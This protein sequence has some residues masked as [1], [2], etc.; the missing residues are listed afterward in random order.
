MWFDTANNNNKMKNTVKFLGVFTFLSIFLLLP[1][2]IKADATYDFYATPSINGTILTITGNGEF[3]ALY[4]HFITFNAD[5]H[6]TECTGDYLDSTYWNLNDPV[7]GIAV[8]CGYASDQGFI[9]VNRSNSLNDPTTLW[10]ISD[11]IYADGPTRIITVTPPDLS[12]VATSTSRTIGYSGFL[13]HGDFDTNRIV[14]DLNNSA[15]ALEQCADVICSTLANNQIKYHHI[16]PLALWGSFNFSDTINGMVQGTYYMTV[17]VQKGSV[18]VFGSCLFYNNITSTSTQFTISTTTNVDL[19]VKSARD[20]VAQLQGSADSA[21]FDSCKIFN[22]PSTF[23]LFDCGQT[24]IYWAF[25]PD[26]R[27]FSHT[28][29]SAKTGFLS[30]APFGY[31]QRFYEILSATTTAP[32]MAMNVPI[33]T[34]RNTDGTYQVATSTL[35]QP[36]EILT[37]AGTVLNEVKDPLSGSGLEDIFG[38]IIKIIVAFTV[39]LVIV[40]DVLG[41]PNHHQQE[42]YRQKDI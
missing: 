10:E 4:T 40:K 42:S 6:E 41:M 11:V 8:R 31:V 25:I 39:L 28:L 34:G 13:T 32:L 23:N 29:E 36:D 21:I 7:K 9:L 37:G 19:L 22:F 35:F 14:F 1:I 12:I 5:T 26:S 18:C 27:A 16:Q 38:P 15:V 24:L 30:K 3:T 20:K 17:T 2:R 33:I